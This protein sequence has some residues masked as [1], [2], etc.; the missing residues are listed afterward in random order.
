[1]TGENAPAYKQNFRKTKTKGLESILEMLLA[2]Y[3]A[4]PLYNITITNTRF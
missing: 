1:M 2:R 3:M 4:T